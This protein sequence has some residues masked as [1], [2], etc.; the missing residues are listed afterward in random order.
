MARL[1]P[2]FPWRPIAGSPPTPVWA[3]THVRWTQGVLGFVFPKHAGCLSLTHGTDVATSG[4]THPHAPCSSCTGA[5]CRVPPAPQSGVSIL[6]LPAGRTWPSRFLGSS[7]GPSKSHQKNI[8]LP[9]HPPF[10][11]PARGKRHNCQNF[12]MCM[13]MGQVGLLQAGDEAHWP[14]LA[15]ATGQPVTCT[16]GGMCVQ[17]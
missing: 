12:I 16:P 11:P 9:P 14:A 1:P 5:S 15:G 4:P 13:W 6:C 7:R 10:L 2:R 3:D 8:S 17:R